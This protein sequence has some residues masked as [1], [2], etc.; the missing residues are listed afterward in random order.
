MT[1]IQSE[2]PNFISSV[3]HGVVVWLVAA[4][5][6]GACFE[7][8]VPSGE[9]STDTSGDGDGDGDGDAG[10]GDGDGDGTVMVMAMA[11]SVVTA[12]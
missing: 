8:P 4:T 9:T 5:V 3:S 11:M 7:D 1:T 10:D 6:L 12:T 2:R